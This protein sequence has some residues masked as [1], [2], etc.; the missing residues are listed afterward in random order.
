MCCKSPAVSRTPARNFTLS[1]LRLFDSNFYAPSQIK[2]PQ[3]VE[4]TLIVARVTV[5]DDCSGQCGHISWCG[6]PDCVD[7]GFTRCKPRFSA[8]VTLRHFFTSWLLGPMP[9]SSRQKLVSQAPLQLFWVSAISF[10]RIWR[11]SKTLARIKWWVC[12]LAVLPPR[13]RSAQRPPR[14]ALFIEAMVPIEFFSSSYG[15]I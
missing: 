8:M 3:P 9:R 2:T 12:C 15:L 1:F 13:E 14:F 11:W 7:C 6:A 4:C 5:G 10:V